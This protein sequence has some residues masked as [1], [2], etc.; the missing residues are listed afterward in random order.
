[1]FTPRLTRPSN[2]DPKWININYGGY[3]RCV[4]GNPSYGYGSVLADCTGY[5]WGRTLENTNRTT[6][7]LSINQAAIWY[8][9]T[10][11]GYP[12]SQ[13]P[14]LGAI[15]CWDDG[16]SGHVAVIEEIQYQN[17]QIVSCTISESVYGGVFFRTRTITAASG[18]YRFTG[19]AFQ[20]FINIPIPSDDIDLLLF[21]RKRR[22]KK[23][24]VTIK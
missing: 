2:T 1:M 9:N 6:C 13:T 19:Y 4:L 12:R 8:L 10:G 7:N 23:G 5:R 11:D 3:N 22:K 21:V 18:W 20:G 16:A 17:G 15:A 14:T 24:T